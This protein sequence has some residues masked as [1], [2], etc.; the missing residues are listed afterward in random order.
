MRPVC[1]ALLFTALALGS[2]TSAAGQKAPRNTYISNSDSAVFCKTDQPLYVDR[3]FKAIWLDTNS[4]LKRATHCEAPQVPPLAHVARIEGYVS[5]DILVNDK[6]KISC[7][8]LVSGH[9]LLATSAI[10]SAKNWTFRPITQRGKRLWFYGHL[11]FHFS[12][13]EIKK[14]ENPCT[15]AHW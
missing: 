14:D 13:G 3:N 9:P 6:G 2:S 12:T 8:G 11:R 7:A 10:E 15:V 5:V 4:L 1:A